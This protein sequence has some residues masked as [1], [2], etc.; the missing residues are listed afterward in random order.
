MIVILKT[1]NFLIYFSS[2]KRRASNKILYHSNLI[3]YIYLGLQITQL[4]CL[5][6][7]FTNIFFQGQITAG[8][9][10]AKNPSFSEVQTFEKCW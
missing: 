5:I 4:I 6:M 2:A 9:V 3:S 8:I 10:K 1:I 7:I